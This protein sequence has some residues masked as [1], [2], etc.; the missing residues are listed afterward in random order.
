VRVF[1]QSFECPAALGAGFLRV[2]PSLEVPACVGQY[3]LQQ[4]Q[5]HSR[6]AMQVCICLGDEVGVLMIKV[7]VM[8]VVLSLRGREQVN[9]GVWGP[10]VP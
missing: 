9:P 10:A 8:V 6:L 1:H 7:N 5:K 4:I 2:C 3:E